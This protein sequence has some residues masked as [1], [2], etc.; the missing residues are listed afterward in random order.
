M[1]EKAA[2]DE[3]EKL[4]QMDVIQ[5]VT[6]PDDAATS[7]NV[8]DTTLVQYMTG[9]TGISNGSEDAELLQESSRQ[10]PLTRTISLQ[11]LH[12]LI[13]FS[14]HVV[15]ICV[16]LQFGCDSIGCQGRISHGAT[17][18]NSLCEDSCMYQKMDWQSSYPLAF[19]TMSPRT[20]QCGFTMASAHRW[21]M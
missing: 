21:S 3:V 14:A 5:P 8:V 15:D 7:E 11:H 16:D 19:E 2:L 10:E 18:G 9:G 1:E 17:D 13:C 4:Y 6:L 12:L 20:M